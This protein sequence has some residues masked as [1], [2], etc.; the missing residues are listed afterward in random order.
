MPPA[1]S[2]IRNA[3]HPGRRKAEKM[4]PGEE[5]ICPKFFDFGDPITKLR[6][7]CALRPNLHAKPDRTTGQ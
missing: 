4:I 6:I 5:H 3:G 7:G 1:T 2:T